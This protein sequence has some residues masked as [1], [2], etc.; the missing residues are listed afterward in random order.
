MK[1]KRSL[2]SL[3]LVP[4]TLVSIVIIFITY[5]TFSHYLQK[6]YEKQHLSKIEQDAQRLFLIMKSRYTNII[7]Q[8]IDDKEYY[9]RLVQALKVDL[10]R[11]LK[12]E[13]SYLKYDGYIY[14][15]NTD[16]MIELYMQNNFIHMKNDSNIKKA[17]IV[18]TQEGDF[19]VKQIEFKPFKWV[20]VIS[21][22]TDDLQRDIEENLLITLLF[23]IIM[24]FFIILIFLLVFNKYIKKDIVKIINHFK[25]KLVNNQYELL[26]VDM[27]S[28]ETQELEDGLNSAIL[29][30][31]KYAK[32]LEIA[33]QN[34][35]ILLSLFDNGD[36]VLVKWNNDQNWS[37]KY[38]SKSI[39]IL[40]GYK[41]EEFLEHKISY[42]DCIYK[43]DLDYVEF[44]V[45]K[46]LSKK[47]RFFKSEPFRLVTKN[48]KLKW[49]ISHSIPVKDKKGIVSHFVSHISDIT[50]LREKEVI[51]SQQSKLA[52]MGEMIG[53]IAHQWRQPLS[54][55]STGATGMLMQKELS[56]LNDESFEQTCN[57]INENAQYLSKTI[58]DFRNFI[59]GDRVKE[60]FTIERS[61]NRLL[62]LLDGSIKHH[63]L[64]VIVD[65]DKTIEIDSYE[66]E[67]TQ[68]LMNIFNNAKDALKENNKE[69]DRLIFIR[70]KR[71]DNFAI[72]KIRDN[73]GGIPEEILPKIFEPYFTTKHKSQGTGLG[74]H[75]TYNLIVSGLQGT[76]EAKN[77]K[78]KYQNTMYKGA[79]FKIVL[80][81]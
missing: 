12:N 73:G 59:K 70:V 15:I 45:K 21:K 19:I 26:Q 69:N 48:G 9:I 2:I 11:D 74:L 40:L 31:E 77:V 72:I 36:T 5:E 17:S 53:N 16:S 24:L 65:I 67:L 32:Q 8:S 44:G 60:K 27:V 49:V 50:Y 52:S 4:I 64:T 35:D 63:N 29:E 14:D 34:Q 71:K 37:V 55:I 78:F 33:N 41:Q 51:V 3:I 66:N 75:M 57:M 30:I 20:V 42:K 76:I 39:S 58:D 7:F 79:E 10:Q 80:K 23:M 25:N 28:Q 81:I 56:A 1:N 43:D 22:N 38:I 62:S 54:I 68:C 61:I 13:L 46:S 47:F 18:S 6:E